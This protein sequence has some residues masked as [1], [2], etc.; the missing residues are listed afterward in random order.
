MDDL[1]EQELLSFHKFLDG[2]I[3]HKTTHLNEW[4]AAIFINFQKV[5]SLELVFRL[6]SQWVN[7]YV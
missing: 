2:Q 7:R 6:T 3:S 1:N 4:R 5:Y